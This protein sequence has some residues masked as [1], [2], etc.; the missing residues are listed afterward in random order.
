MALPVPVVPTTRI[1]KAVLICALSSVCAAFVFSPLKTVFQHDDNTT[2][3]VSAPPATPANHDTDALHTAQPVAVGASGAL[4]SSAVASAVASATQAL[5]PTTESVTI[6]SSFAE[7]MQRLGVDPAMSAVIAHAYSGQID[8]RRD[9]RK[10]DRI[11]LVLGPETKPGDVATGAPQLQASKPVDQREPL[12]VRV[13]RGDTD[14]DLFLHRD[15]KGK[16][17][18]YTANGKATTPS[19]SRYPLRYSRV[20]SPFARRRLDPV[21]H[22]WQSHDGVDLAAP[23]GTPVHATAQGTISTIGWETGYGKFILID[24]A[25]PYQTAFAHLS[26]FAKGLHMG[27]HVKRGQ[28]I[29]YVGMTGWSTGPH[30]HYEVRVNDIARNPLTVVLPGDTPL[31]GEERKRFAQQADRLSGLL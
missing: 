9:L 15:L 12:A 24:N 13:S 30:L 28:V 8:F 14:H 7:A 20:S 19:F 3:S 26:R 5:A 29:G 21:T 25:P 2:P 31:Q 4:A 27:S 6:D 16:P 1:G 18:Y 11:S 23:I 17:F 22:R 10:G